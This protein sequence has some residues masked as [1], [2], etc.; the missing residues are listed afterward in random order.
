MAETAKKSRK[1]TGRAARSGPAAGP[2]PA[3]RTLRGLVPSLSAA[4]AAALRGLFATP[5]GWTLRDNGV[6]QFMP[7]KPAPAAQTFALD[8]EGTRI[9]LA[10]QAPDDGGGLHWSDY[11]G[12]SRVLAWSLAHEAQLMRLSEAFG[13]VL[14][15]VA[16]DD[17]GTDGTDALWLDFIVDEEPADDSASRMPAL[18]GAL[19]MPARWSERLLERADPPYEDAPTALGRWR[20]LGVPVSLQWRLPPLPFAEWSSLQPGDVLVAGRR[21]R[22]PQALACAG[23]LAWPLA[24]TPDGWRIDGPP[25]HL[26]T[27]AQETS[28]MTDTLPDAGGDAAGDLPADGEALARRLPVDVS[29]ELGR[30]ELRVGEL[31][32]LQPG[33]V[34]PLAV[35]VEGA[36]VTIRANGQAVGQGEVVAVGDTLGVRLLWW[37]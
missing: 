30:S 16:D 33:Y 3:T 35:P 8:A 12:R 4:E 20:E 36:N 31:S 37:N 18:Q 17:A 14:T 27:V 21:S 23:D 10:L 13:V 25:R 9:G 32:S 7:G 34:F 1:S 15:P 2:A 11:Q 6:L 5:Q 26:P 29:F 28:P 24:P 19:R 22:P